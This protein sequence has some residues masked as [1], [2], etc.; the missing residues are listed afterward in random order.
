LRAAG[1]NVEVHDDHFPSDATDEDWLRA[2]GAKG[3][4]VLT[5]DRRIRY[6]PNEIAALKEAKVVAVV[7]VAG[8]LIGAE[9]ADLFVKTLRKIERIAGSATPPAVFTFGRDRKLKSVKL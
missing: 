7:L 9:M 1:A 4:I 5:K 3:W 8:N 6:R 2:V